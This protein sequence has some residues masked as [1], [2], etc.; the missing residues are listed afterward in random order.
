LLPEHVEVVR[1]DA[2]D[3]SSMVAAATGAAVVHQAMNPP[4]HRWPEL[5][6]QLQAS[7]LAAAQAVG[8]RYVSIDNLYMYSQGVN[9]IREDSPQRPRTVKG[10]V[11]KEAGDAVLAAHSDGRVEATILRSADYFGPGVTDSA[12]GERALR[13]LLAGK[14]ADLLGRTD[15]PHSYAFIEDVGQAAATLATSDSAWGQVWFTPHAPA[16]T[17]GRMV[18]LAAT[19][20]SVTPRARTMGA[21]MLRL[22]GLF[23]PAARE[24][25]EMLYEFTE[26][27]IVDS[28]KFS[29]AFHIE[30]T[31]LPDAMRRTVAWYR[32]L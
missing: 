19:E 32:T 29:A 31:P 1:A 23:I 28:T 26:P 13:P 14:R 10:R 9:P 25:V 30:A 12:F 18:E 2:A 20:A 16:V 21:A 11:R 8:A 3:P 24:G 5:F 27:F 17:Q 15:Q 6:P 7:A 22:G 4:Y